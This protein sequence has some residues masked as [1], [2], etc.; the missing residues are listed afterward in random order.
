MIRGR[1]CAVGYLDEDDRV[2]DE[3]S[4]GPLYTPEEWAAVRERL[5]ALRGKW[6]DIK[7]T[8]EDLT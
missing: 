5:A 2:Q 4:D 7:A 3:D 1:I 8:S 6:A